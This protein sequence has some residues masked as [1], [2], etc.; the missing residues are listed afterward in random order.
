[1]NNTY[2]CRFDIKNHMR[3]C[4]VTVEHVAKIA[5]VSRRTVVNWRNRGAVPHRLRARIAE[6][7]RIGRS[8]RAGRY[9]H[10]A[11]KPPDSP[12]YATAHVGPVVLRLPHRASGAGVL[13]FTLRRED[14][15]RLAVGR[16][17]PGLWWGRWL[18]QDMEWSVNLASGFVQLV[19]RT[20]AA[21]RWPCP[22]PVL[23]A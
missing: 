22:S 11:S 17:T 13:R 19:G 21:V 18:G 1:M 23:W 12:N 20:L 6:L 14:A 15:A 7:F 9:R 3:Y 2:W 5:R 16:I 10:W 4:L 8:L